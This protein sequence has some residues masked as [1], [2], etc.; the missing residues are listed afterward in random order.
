MPD[1]ASVVLA[2]DTRGLAKGE[3]SLESLARTGEQVERR[4]EKST[5]DVSKGFTRVSTTATAAQRSVQRMGSGFGGA[6]NQ[7]QN[8]AFQVGD[9]ATQVGSGQRASVALGQQLPQLL[10]GFGALGAVLGAVVAIGVPLA[11]SLFR[12]RDAV[13]EIDQVSLGGVRG[14]ISAL[15][16]LQESYNDLVRASG[17][18]QTTASRQAL[19]ALG[20]EYEAK[21]ALLRLDRIKAAQQAEALRASISN[22]QEE[23]KLLAERAALTGDPDANLREFIRTRAQ[24][25][26]LKILRDMIGANK[27]IFNELQRQNAELTLVEL[28]LGEIDQA[29]KSGAN[30]AFDLSKGGAAMVTTLNAAADAAARIADNLK[31]AFD[32][33]SFLL[34]RRFAAE[35]ALFAQEVAPAGEGIGRNKPAS[36]SLA[37]G[38]AAKAIKDATKAAKEAAKESERILQPIT[39]AVDGLANAF[40]NFMADGFRDFKG[41]ASSILNTFKSMI[42]QMIATAVK[43][44]ILIGLGFSAT[45][46]AA[47]AAGS[48]IIGGSGFLGGIGSGLS[49]AVSTFATKGLAAGLSQSFGAIGGIFSGGGAAAIGT[50]LPAIGLLAGGVALLFGLFKKKRKP[51]I[52]SADFRAVQEGL[53]LTQQAL[54]DTSKAG[55]R[56]AKSLLSELGGKDQFGELTKFFFDNFVSEATKRSQSAQIIDAVFTGLGLSA[57]KTASAF[58]NVVQSLDLTTASGR[59]TYAEL[60]KVAPVFAGLNGTINDTTVAAA[61]LNAALQESGGF[62]TN[63][64]DAQRAAAFQRNGIAFNGPTGFRVGAGILVPGQ[65][66]AI[67]AK[68]D[69]LLEVTT[70]GQ[71]AVVRNTKK[72]LNI[73]EEWRTIGLPATQA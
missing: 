36:P 57:P 69:E 22:L 63:V 55:Q 44:K 66:Q 17:G 71:I 65:E 53:S 12:T 33:Q 38:G 51:I 16:K 24:S 11:A 62:F 37:K 61:S 70:A 46:T 20:R 9:F 4:L 35:E 29:L 39:R 23:T 59:E 6:R 18:A 32:N 21:V 3:A 15:A 30:S 26:Q 13:K 34:S 54:L 31:R 48:A 60:L 1:F 49:T 47:S 5:D 28:S 64:V 45:G 10:G 7:I 42:A 50:A 8:V 41:F 43:N 73:F 72:S 2:A 58:A 52:S 40:G 27:E 25:E 68:L 14:Q 56:A 67:S 19:T